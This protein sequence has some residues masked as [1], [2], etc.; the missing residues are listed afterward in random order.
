LNPLYLSR[1]VLL[2]HP[3]P[4]PHDF[5]P[6]Y[7]MT[8][9]VPFVL[10]LFRALCIFFPPHLEMASNSLPRLCLQPSPHIPS[11]FIVLVSE[12]SPP[13]PGLFAQPLPSSPF[14]LF[15]SP[16]LFC[17]GAVPPPKK[18]TFGTALIAD[19]GAKFVPDFFDVLFYLDLTHGPSFLCFLN[20]SSMEADG[21]TFS[22][23]CLFF[24]TWFFFSPVF[25]YV[26]S[27]LFR[28]RAKPYKGHRSPT[29]P[30]L[31]RVRFPWTPSSPSCP[32]PFQLPVTPKI[33]TRFQNAPFCRC[34]FVQPSLPLHQNFSPPYHPQWS[35]SPP[36]SLPFKVCL[37]NGVDKKFFCHLS[38]FFL[39]LGFNLPSFLL[40][41]LSFSFSRKI[42]SPFWLPHLPVSFS[43]WGLSFRFFEFTA[44]PNLFFFWKYLSSPI[45]SQS[46]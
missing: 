3:P 40:L 6:P 28:P 33:P 23:L 2:C 10:V 20:S 43:L 24:A 37:P 21:K 14:P 9:L 30:K 19:F 7:F 36:F 41:L 38:S 39:R 1:L 15:L 4:P 17:N 31:S 35:N 26:P 32:P 44:S 12:T 42:L 8:C 5:Y 22:P 18:E 46:P 11:V 27:F 13:S 16:Q 34:F 25:F 45:Y 29:K